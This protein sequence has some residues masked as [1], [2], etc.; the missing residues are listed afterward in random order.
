MHKCQAKPGSQQEFYNIEAAAAFLTIGTT[1]IYKA[2][3]QRQIKHARIG[4]SIRIKH[5]HL[6][7]W[8]EEQTKPTLTEINNQN[9]KRHKH[10]IMKSHPNRKEK[11]GRP[12][13]WPPT[14]IISLQKLAKRIE[15]KMLK[16]EAT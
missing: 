14:T 3:Q 10:I 4:K 12:P 16:E 5:D 1:T 8:V 7:Q 9:S 11:R 13:L 6:I 15:Q 2:I